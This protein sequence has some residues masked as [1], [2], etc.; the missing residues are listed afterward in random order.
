MK[1]RKRVYFLLLVMICL[2]RYVFAQSN[3][4]QFAYLGVENGL[5]QGTVMAMAQDNKGFLWIGTYE[6]LSRFDGYE[7]FTF[8]HSVKDSSSL[9]NNIIHDLV[10]D[11][12][13]YIWIAT[14]DGLSKFD[15]KTEKF[16]NYRNNKKQPKSLPVNYIYSLLIDSKSRLWL[17]TL[18]EGLCYYDSQTDSFGKIP[19]DPNNNTKFPASDVLTMDEDDNGTLWIGTS[20]GL[21]QFDPHQKR[22]VKIYKNDSTQKPNWG[23][24]TIRAVHYDKTTDELWLGTQNTGLF[25][26]NPRTGKLK[27]YPVDEKGV[28]GPA[29]NNI[30]FFCEDREKNLWI[31]TQ[32]GGVS[33]YNRRTGMFTTF[34]NNPKDLKSLRYN[35]VIR[36]FEDKTGNIW[37]TFVNGLCVY[38]KY[39]K[40]F[41]VIRSNPLDPTGLPADAVRAVHEA[42]N[43]NIWVGTSEGLSFFDK[44]TGNFYTYKNKPNNPKSLSKNDVRAIYEDKSGAIWAGTNGGGINRLDPVKKTFARFQVNPDRKKN[45]ISS[46]TVWCITQDAEQNIWVGTNNGGLNKFSPQNNRWEAL[47]AEKGKNNSL[48]VNA[49]RT[50][51]ISRDGVLWV[52]TL[53]GGLARYN[54]VDKTFQIFSKNSPERYGFQSDNILS[55]HEDHEGILWIGTEAGLHRFDPL[56]KE[57]KVWRE[58][59]GLIN[60]IVYAVLP[61]NDNNLWLSTNKGITKFSKTNQTFRNYDISDGIANNEFNRGAYSRLRSGELIFGGVNGLTFFNPSDI[62]DNPISPE[63]VLTS[64]KKYNKVMNL[65]TSISYSHNVTIPESENFVTFEFSALNF[66][67]PEK[68]QYAFKLEGFDKDW[69]VSG[70]KRFAVYTNLSGGTYTFYV[71]AA[72]NDGRWNETAANIQIV[73]IPKFYNSYWFR[74]SGGLI[75]VALVVFFYRRKVKNIR[76]L[77]SLLMEQAEA[78]LQI[79]Q[80]QQLAEEQSQLLSKT[81][82]QTTLL[83]EQTERER[84]YLHTNVELMLTGMNKFAGGDLTVQLSPPHNND[85]I[86]EMTRLVNGFNFAVQTIHTLV[87]QVVELAATVN[88]T[89]RNVLESSR[90]M[91]DA[92]AIQTSQILHIKEQT[93]KISDAIEQTVHKI[94]TANVESGKSGSL[95]NSGG[96]LVFSTI[97]QMNQVVEIMNQSSTILANLERSGEKVGEIVEVIRG[98]SDQTNLLALN[99][100]IEAARAG[101]AGRGFAVVADEVRRLA[102]RTVMATKEITGVIQETQEGIQ[103]VIGSMNQST[104]GLE[105]VTLQAEE[106]GKALEQII[107][108]TDTVMTFIQEISTLSKE[109]SLAG[110]NIAAAME[111]I[112]QLT[113]QMTGN[114]QSLA[115]DSQMLHSSTTTL[116]QTTGVFTVQSS[117]PE[118]QKRLRLT[119]AP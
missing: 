54:P 5:P 62:K 46:N 19:V 106:S 55:I 114:I 40:S 21:C 24:N 18:S 33:C 11:K 57:C 72:N 49:V 7:F 48:P 78:T 81:H 47:K 70:T 86:D 38:Q 35:N 91:K 102:E 108:A 29:N 52:G 50:L 77:Q 87:E 89:N 98:I 92:A 118:T 41:T 69:N 107:V 64:L 80:H 31:A 67:S 36:L 111:Q 27:Q 63:V 83:A 97:R 10:V 93:Q 88:E 74:V 53:G 9:P 51:L 110:K 79:Q 84:L 75:I 13:G 65:D 115:D 16:T 28:N 44:I 109:Q 95:A 8:K 39:A 113:E 42:R 100:A 43:G 76:R 101:S 85:E 23:E 6:G 66:I 15:P 116:R 119:Q 99:A 17:G 12:S 112:S 61:D 82:L 117:F 60:D 37:V 105:Q 4:S 32:Y 25:R 59:D 90:S 103:S 34:R 94:A 68:N 104:S 20:N 30:K 56:K 1:L 58:T 73:I 26:F 3:H 45:T 2:S 96:N 22:I 14:E 71:K